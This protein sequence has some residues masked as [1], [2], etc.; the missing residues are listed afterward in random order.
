MLQRHWLDKRMGI[1]VLGA[2]CQ[3]GMEGASTDGGILRRSCKEAGAQEIAS[4]LKR[5]TL[6]GVKLPRGPSLDQVGLVRL[7]A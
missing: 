1:D 4:Y 3:A 5:S 6:A 7:P 2:H